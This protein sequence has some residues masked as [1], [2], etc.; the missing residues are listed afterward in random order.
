V[1]LLVSV[2]NAGEAAAALEGGADI[3]DAKEPDA[4]ALG[5]VSL[6]TLR[7]ILRTSDGRR[8]V[9]A[10]LG[11]ASDEAALSR[12]ACSFVDAGA[13]L[14]KIGL[15]GV[16]DEARAEELIGSA[17]RAAGADCVVAV[18][19]ADYRNAGSLAPQSVLRVAA[20]AGVAGVLID[21]ADKRG[22]GLR[23]LMPFPEL[24]DWV[25]TAHHTG[26][27]AALAGKLAADDV[28]ALALTGADIIGVRG[29][30]CDGGR[31][32][33]LCAERVRR[34]HALATTPPDY[35]SSTS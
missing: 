2:R 33:R 6:D 29:A 4:G 21:T 19:Y 28:A 9:T 34:L 15:A 22:P 35:V 24:V 1:R 3:I 32:G 5:A 12:L 23:D 25:A 16:N 11:D 26:L 13:T 20:R 18:A 27:M 17:V 7:A 10:A 8:P 14:I 31:T 30:A